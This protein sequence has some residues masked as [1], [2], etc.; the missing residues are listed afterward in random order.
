MFIKFKYNNTI[1]KT[2][3]DINT[4]KELYDVA[5]RLFGEDNISSQKF[6]YTDEED[7]FIIIS[8]DGDMEGLLEEYQNRTKKGALVIFLRESAPSPQPVDDEEFEEVQDDVSSSEDQENEKPQ[9]AK[10]GQQ[11]APQVDPKELERLEANHQQLQDELHSCKR[12]M[13]DE[14]KRVREAGKAR[15]HE[16]KQKLK[17]SKQVLKQK[18]SKKTGRSF[19]HRRGKRNGCPQFVK[20]MISQQKDFEAK[21][22]RPWPK[23]K[24]FFK[25]FKDKYPQFRRNPELTVKLIDILAKPLTELLENSAELVMKENPDLVQKGKANKEEIEK[26]REEHRRNR[27]HSSSSSSSSKSRS[28]KRR[29][30]HR[31]RRHQGRPHR[32]RDQQDFEDKPDKAE[33]RKRIDAVAGVCPHLGHKEIKRIVK[34]D[35]KNG[36]TLQQTI[37]RLLNEQA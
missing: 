5:A 36:L 23:L 24:S 10:V 8:N 37:T 32:R 11:P 27:A 30:H 2:R 34:E 12:S 4:Y 15:I 13:K 1:R 33:K 21:F 26:L 7:E 9:D 20:A 19:Q 16:L 25:D 29:R 6:F 18:G 31:G 3:S 35:M 17:E 28:N 14:I 22:G